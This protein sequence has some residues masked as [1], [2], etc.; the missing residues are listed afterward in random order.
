MAGLAV[1]LV[2]A[3]GLTAFEV[4]DG[5]SRQSEAAEGSTQGGGLDSPSNDAEGGSARPLADASPPRTES[6]DSAPP[7]SA[8]PDN[9]PPHSAAPDDAAPDSAAPDSA[10]TTA[11][12]GAGEVTRWLRTLQA[13]DQR[14]S[15]VFANADPAGL[16]SVYVRGS[17]PWRA[18]QSLLATYRLRGLR[19]EG[20]RL[21]ISGL[22]IQQ[23]ATRTPDKSAVVLR[24][25]D[26]LVA[27]AV[28]D[29]TGRRTPLPPG[30]AATR[31][32]TL[33]AEEAGWRISG[34]VAV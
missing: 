11:P 20:L 4:L 3:T 23:R 31:L 34:V 9:A 1:V 32:V 18:D 22:D 12:G 21:D 29:R 27:G 26:R 7:D 24:V 30:R 2:L 33:T 10:P 8:R 13:L 16:D 14:R 19:V 28:V 25:V 17:S 5:A 15:Q 6:P